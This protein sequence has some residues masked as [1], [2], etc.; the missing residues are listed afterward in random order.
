MNTNTLMA[1][2]SPQ[3]M[4]VLYDHIDCEDWAEVWEQEYV[5]VNPTPQ[6]LT[7]MLLMDIKTSTDIP[8]EAMT[9]I[10]HTK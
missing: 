5:I 6:M 4:Q 7:V 10:K 3:Q 8:F 9:Y 1:T 2:I